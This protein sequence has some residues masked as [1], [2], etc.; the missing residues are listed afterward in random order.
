M[1]IWGIITVLFGALF[2]AIILRILC[3]F[4]GRIVNSN[5]RIPK[6]LHLLFFAV[7]VP[8]VTLLIVVFTCNKINR[9]IERV[10]TIV[11][12]FL[13]ADGK[14]VDQLRRLINQVS[15][16]NDVEELTDYLSENF[17][18]RISAEHPIVVRYV[19]VNKLLEKTD[20]G[21]KISSLLQGGDM[22][23]VGVEMMQQLVQTVSSWLTKGIKAKI[24]AVQLKA[25]FT[26]IILQSIAFG[27]V[28]YSACR[29]HKKIQRH[30]LKEK[31]ASNKRFGE[32][33]G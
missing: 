28:M 8:T 22:V 2:V 15:T 13:M 14:F 4:S 18:N 12:K 9:T 19:D 10:D 16:S 29:F 30:K 21:K 17:V 27:A 7:A 6:L 3:A 32:I 26:V 31:Q 11:A 33:G 23:D 1:F 20:L 25:F 5:Y 24:K